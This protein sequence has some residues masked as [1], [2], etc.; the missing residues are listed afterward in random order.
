[1]FKELK[2]SVRIFPHSPG[3]Y[4]MRNEKDTILYIGKAKDLRK[5]VL[6]YFTGG[7]DLKTQVLVKKIHSI[8]YIVTGNNYEALILE[9]NLI[10]KWS[11][12]YNINLKDGKSYPVIR[13]T[14]EDFP[15]LFKT[16]RIIQD[17]SEYFGPFADVGKLDQFLELIEKLFP[18]RKCR[19]PLR[20]RYSPCLYYHIGRCS[21]P[22]AGKIDKEEYQN[23]V[24]KVRKMLSGDTGE[25][26]NRL[27]REMRTASESMQFERAAEARDTLIALES[28]HTNQQ[29]EDF[30]LEKRDYAACAMREHLCTISVFQMREGKLIGRELFRAE[31]FGNETDVLADFALQYYRETEDV[32]NYLYVSHDVDTE[33][34]QGY[35]DKE[36]AANMQAVKPEDG[37]HYRILK[38][39]LENA[40]MDVD[41]RLKS[42]ENLTGLEALKEDLDLKILP[43]RIEGFDIAQLSGKYPVA[44]LISFYNGIPDKKNY[45]R[46]HIKTLEGRIDD[47]EAIREAVARRY[48]RIVNEGLEEPDLIL[49]DGGKGQVNAAREIL[50]S[51]GLNAVPVFGLAKEFEEIHF[52]DRNEP[53]R[54]PTGSDGLK[55][56]QG[57]RD[58]THRFATT[59]NKQLRAK[60]T[61]FS[62]LESIA[63]IGQVRSRKLMQSFGSLEAIAAA[64]PKEISE[65]CG[66]PER[67]AKLLLKQ[68]G[69]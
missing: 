29:V 9:N 68:L 38:M 6:S 24:S 21:A 63:G 5:R 60:D 62:L 7:R 19:G 13:I 22:C 54:L 36:L 17:G 8:E 25:V 27:R 46:F 57:V 3:V 33:L 1:M 47:Y 40:V 59:F 51:L 43:R 18:L 12:R 34:L 11:P 56:L 41:K 45:R 42:R 28:V 58:E 20:K 2:E 35:F 50:D 26:E 10:K 15:R 67:T 23:L 61:G 39:A 37:K 53:L 49:I 52:A 65:K 32:P 30:N 44:S 16:R 55:V 48:T 14:N 4:L 31:T 69:L 64:T 66:L